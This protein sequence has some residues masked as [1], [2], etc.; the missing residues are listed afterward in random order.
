VHLNLTTAV[1]IWA[2]GCVLFEL[3]TGDELFHPHTYNN[4]EI[5]ATEDHLALIIE[6]LGP[7]PEW[8]HTGC[9][10]IGNDGKPRHVAKLL[11]WP[12]DRVLREKYKIDDPLLVELLGGMLVIDPNNRWTADQCLSHSW[13]S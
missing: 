1:D 8:M 3:Y 5:S 13:F 4:W 6:L 9:R 10:F 2:L 12:L 7:L 11:Y